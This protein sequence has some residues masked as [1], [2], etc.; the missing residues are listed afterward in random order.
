VNNLPKF[1][2]RSSLR[3]DHECI[4]LLIAPPYA[5]GAINSFPVY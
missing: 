1:M 5:V 4:A 3:P 2:A